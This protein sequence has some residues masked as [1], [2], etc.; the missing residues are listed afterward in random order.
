[1]ESI[2]TQCRDDN[3]SKPETSDDL[4][5]QY[6][7]YANYIAGGTMLLAKRYVPISDMAKVF[8]IVGSPTSVMTQTALSMAQIQKND[9]TPLLG[10]LS[11][12][13]STLAIFSKIGNAAVMG[14]MITGITVG[15]PVTMIATGLTIV[16]TVAAVAAN[17]TMSDILSDPEFWDSIKSADYNNFEKYFE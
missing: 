13:P 8:G 2:M 1:M 11:M 7:K 12:S 15:L 6:F 5:I 17:K 10:G 14:A 4:T 16:A 3:K 9:V